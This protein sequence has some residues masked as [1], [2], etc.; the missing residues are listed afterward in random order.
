MRQPQILLVVLCFNDVLVAQ[1]LQVFVFCFAD[2]E[3]FCIGLLHYYL[4]QSLLGT[5]VKQEPKIL[6]AKNFMSTQTRRR[7]DVYTT[8]YMVCL[9]VNPT[10]TRVIFCVVHEYRTWN[11]SGVFFWSYKNFF[12]KFNECIKLCV[13]NSS[14]FN[15]WLIVLI[16]NM[17][18]FI[19]S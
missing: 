18:I 3:P 19:N 1:L 17:I 6:G 7:L 8:L 4:W 14:T 15:F 11:S 9:G 12:K 2:W 16:I 10:H 13:L 5:S